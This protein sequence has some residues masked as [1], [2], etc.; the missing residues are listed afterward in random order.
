M[1]P[2]LLCNWWWWLVPLTIVGWLAIMCDNDV[3]NLKWEVCRKLLAV[4]CFMAMA[5]VLAAILTGD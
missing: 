3:G 1:I 4:S 2:W 5:L